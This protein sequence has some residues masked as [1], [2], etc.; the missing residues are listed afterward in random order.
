MW[1][2]DLI[3]TPLMTRR[4]IAGVRSAQMVVGLGQRPGAQWQRES[5]ISR[6]RAETRAFLRCHHPH[7]QHCRRALLPDRVAIR[8]ARHAGRSPRSLSAPM[9]PAP[10]CV[11]SPTCGPLSP[12][13]P[14]PRVIET[15]GRVGAGAGARDPRG[16]LFL[17]GWTPRS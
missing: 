17:G 5:S 1:A 7:W 9:H 15:V 10:S 6:G 16:A 11:A 4:C 2:S 3:K 14:V 8:T 12:T 13:R